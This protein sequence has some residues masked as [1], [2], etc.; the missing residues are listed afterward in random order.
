MIPITWP[1][2][3]KTH[4]FAP[5]EQEGYHIMFKE[6]VTWLSEITGFDSVSLQPN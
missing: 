4:P 6:L 5:L 1:E 3:G 2:F